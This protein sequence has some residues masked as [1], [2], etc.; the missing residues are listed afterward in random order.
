MFGL[1]AY[2]FRYGVLRRWNR[3]K[4]CGYSNTFRADHTDPYNILFHVEG[5]GLFLVSHRLGLYIF[6]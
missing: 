1:K 3:T 5:M 6:I 4:L 2:F